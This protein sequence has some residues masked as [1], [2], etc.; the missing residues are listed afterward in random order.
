MNQELIRDAAATEKDLRWALFRSVVE[1][2]PIP[3]A[4]RVSAQARAN[5][6]TEVQR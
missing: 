1:A 4:T 3:P 5:E 6:K 2:T